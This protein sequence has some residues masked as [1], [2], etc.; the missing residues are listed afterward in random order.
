MGDAVF[1]PRENDV[2]PRALPWTANAQK[3]LPEHVLFVRKAKNVEEV[4]S[5]LSW[6][7]ARTHNF[8]KWQIAI[9]PAV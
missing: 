4:A 9:K 1:V 8:Q 3:N 7:A 6:I 2:V 5:D